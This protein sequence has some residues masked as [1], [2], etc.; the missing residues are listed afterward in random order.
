[1]T[2]PSHIS[3]SLAQ[4]IG[5]TVGLIN[6]LCVHERDLPFSVHSCH[7]P[8]SKKCTF[9]ES[10]ILSVYF[11][12]LNLDLLLSLSF[13]SS[14]VFLSI[15][16]QFEIEDSSVLFFL[17]ALYPFLFPCIGSSN[18]QFLGLSLL[19]TFCSLQDMARCLICKC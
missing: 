16:E 14:L 8:S 18:I 4:I 10:A 19:Y 13:F 3:A 6:A 1:M 11:Y 2:E 7:V 5:F 12:F 9:S 15:F 17:F